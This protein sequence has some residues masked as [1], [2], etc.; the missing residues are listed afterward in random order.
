MSKPASSAWRIR[1]YQSGDEEGIYALF[2]QVFHKSLSHAQWQW[3]LHTL[4]S[5]V[6]NEWVAEA[7]G[8]IVGHYAVMPIHFKV[9]DHEV[10]VP[11]TCDAMT[12]PS[13]QRNGIFIALS[14]RANEKWKTTEAPFKIGFPQWERLGAVL[15]EV[16]WQRVVRVVWMKCLLQPIA[17]IARKLGR[18]AATSLPKHTLHHAVDEQVQVSRVL[19]AG[20]EFDQLWQRVAASYRIVAVRDRAWAQWRYLDAPGVE[21]CLLL[22]RRD[23]QACGYL[24][25]RIYRDSQK[26]WAVVLDCFASPEDHVTIH[27]LVQNAKRELAAER[28][29]SLAA[30][31]VANSPLYSEFCREGFWSTRQGFD[32]SVVPYTAFEMNQR[33][34]FVTGAEG[35]VV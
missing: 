28:V 20:S 6:E 4:S 16:H 3:K 29:E 15:D 27:A 5:P 23:D 21:Q 12:H 25:Y 14:R 9:N 22:A 18:R 1:A 34:W 10:I 31:V 35:D 13:F 30:L 26:A 32:F 7:D 17:F 19:A 33:D 24:A 8:R 11:H 2:E